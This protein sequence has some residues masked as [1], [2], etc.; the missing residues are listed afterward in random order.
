ML[1]HAVQAAAYAMGLS[2]VLLASAILVYLHHNA[3]PE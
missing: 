1:E 3:R 2:G